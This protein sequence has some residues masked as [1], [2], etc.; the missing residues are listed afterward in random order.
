MNLSKLNRILFLPFIIIP[1]L[2]LNIEF[3]K[4]GSNIY[5]Y[6]FFPFFL[7]SIFLSFLK[8]NIFLYNR[9]EDFRESIYTFI[10]IILMLFNYNGNEQTFFYY[11]LSLFSVL[12][13]FNLFNIK[14]Q[15]DKKNY[16]YLFVWVYFLINLYLLINNSHFLVEENDNIRRFNGLFL[17][18]SVLGVMSICLYVFYLK[19]S[20]TRKYTEKVVLFLILFFVVYSTKSRIDLFL[21]ILMPIYFYTIS[22]NKFNNQKNKIF[23]VILFFL[24]FFYPIYNFIK[25]Y[26]NAGI[27][28][29]S[30]SSDNSRI[31]FSLKV[32]ENLIE[33]NY[34]QLLFGHGANKSLSLLDSRDI[35][36]HNDFLRIIYDYGIIFTVVFFKKIY[37]WFKKDRMISYI[38]L[39]YLTSFY[40]NMV[41]D[42]YIVTLIVCSKSVI[43]D[44]EK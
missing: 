24:L 33:S 10:L 15:F 2:F 17:S 20:P 27:R 11:I 31:I 40:H 22:N 19:I 39:V 25:L 14:I 42:L 26:Y 16:V 41:F 4:L 30:A 13:F 6:V 9:K 34:I 3:R 44:D 7:F 1:I 37:Y 43:Q 29:N 23:M 35:M 18:S 38:V 12:L 8:S 21:M 36:P 28:D 5:F 32:F